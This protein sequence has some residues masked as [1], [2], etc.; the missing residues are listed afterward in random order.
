MATSTNWPS[1]VRSAWR[2]AARTP[3]AS[4]IAGTISPTPGPTF[5]GCS[6]SGPVMPMIPPIACATTSKA[7]Q[8]A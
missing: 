8:S 3:T 5:N 4:S 7:G 2:T 6:R 1:P